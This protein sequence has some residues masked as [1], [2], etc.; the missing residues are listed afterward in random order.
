MSAV[1]RRGFVQAITTVAGALVLGI[2]LPACS[3]MDPKTVAHYRKTGEFK[4]NAWLKIH[5]D[6]RIVFL[7]DRVEMGQGTA[8]S[9][10]TLIAEEL[11]VSPSKI[12]VEHAPASREYDLPTMDGGMQLTGGSS[13]VRTSFEPLQKAGAVARE[14]LR[15][16]AAAKWGVPASE[17]VL[18]EGVVKHPPTGQKATYGKMA[19]GASHQPVPDVALKSPKDRKWIGKSITRVDGRSKV[20]G[21]I[22]YG[23]DVQMPDLLTGVVIRCPVRGGTVKSFDAARAKTSS[24]VVDIFAIPSGIAVVA[25]SYWEARKAAKQVSV[26]WDNGPLAAYSS[27]KLWADFQSRSKTPGAVVKDEGDVEKAWSAGKVITA[28]YKVPYLS[29]ATMEPQNAT[30]HVTAD[31]CEVWAPTQGPGLTVEEVV[32]LTGLDRSAITVHTTAIGGAFGR[33]SMTDF[34]AEAV[35]ASKKVGKPVKVIWSR[36]DDMA[37]DFYRPM[38][39]NVLKASVDGTGNILG[40]FHRIVA[41]PVAAQ[42]TESWVRAVSPTGM[43]EAMKQMLGRT[44]ANFYR[45]GTLPDQSV[46]DGARDF[47][48]SIPSI[49]V[50]HAPLEV[51]VPC[52]FWRSV[53]HSENTYVVEHFLDEIAREAKK[54]PLELRRSLLK[55]E[56]HHIAVLDR[57]AKEAHWGNAPK[58]VFQ[59]IAVCHAF[60][61]YCAQVAEIT[62]E[63]TGPKVRR[64]VAAIHCGTVVNPDLV[65]AQVEG[66]IVFA[67]S[68]LRQQITFKEGKVEQTNFHSYE[69][70]RMADSPKIEVHIIDSDLPPTGAGELGVPPLAP[71]VANAVLAATGKPV[72]TMPMELA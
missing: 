55:H 45:G 68:A 23:I 30:A 34:V 52:G 40:W 24:G 64:V 69:M 10:A 66:G 20:D 2:E 36:E 39:F 27:D 19:E 3:T 47:A 51:P 11:E 37:N 43:P 58:G 60:G 50:E 13:S 25:K 62:M 35:L 54:D 16:A 38:A 41:Q 42:V 48:Y 46:L 12:I 8:T 59:G 28:E 44:A 72:R 56:P 21:S 1:S 7:L 61:S 70:V 57:V 4:P 33:R 63:N 14:M 5:S 32:G 29:H 67:L 71:A 65:R 15:S 49:K 22:V 26:T 9:H 17:L 6:D 31:R 18:E 53:G